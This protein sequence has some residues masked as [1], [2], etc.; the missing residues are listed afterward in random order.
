MNNVCAHEHDMAWYR[1]DQKMS[2]RFF[3][4]ISIDLINANILFDSLLNWKTNKKYKMWLLRLLQACC[5]GNSRDATQSKND[6]DGLCMG[7]DEP[8][9]DMLF[10]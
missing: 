8:T 10:S 4:I 7:D 2:I 3:C 5:Y 6:P 1:V 9:K